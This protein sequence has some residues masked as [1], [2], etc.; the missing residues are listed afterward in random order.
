MRSCECFES[1]ELT[2]NRSCG[3]VLQIWSQLEG[4][5][6]LCWHK[7]CVTGAPIQRF[8]MAFV[9]CHSK[10]R[11]STALIQVRSHAQK[12]FIRLE[13]TGLGAGVPPA[14]RKARW[15]DKQIAD[16][17]DGSTD[18]DQDISGLNFQV[19]SSSMSTFDY[20]EA[21]A[22]AGSSAQCNDCQPLTSPD[23]SYGSLQS[24]SSSVSSA[25]SQSV[26]AHA[27][28]CPCCLQC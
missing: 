25:A 17:L 15:T 18:S 4:H 20:H 27:Q 11:T 21:R 14:R 10:T 28:V 23:H 5:C 1:Q 8:H 2:N 19:N 12:H 9:W 3:S 26:I 7:E 22:S 24:C 13:K 6:C 16:S